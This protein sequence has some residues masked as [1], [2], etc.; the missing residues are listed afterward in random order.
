MRGREPSHAIV[1]CGIID[2][3]RRFDLR[4]SIGFFLLSCTEYGFSGKEETEPVLVRDTGEPGLVSLEVT[5]RA[6]DFGQVQIGEVVEEIVTVR[7]VGERAVRIDG[8]GLIDDTR[9]FTATWTGPEWLEPGEQHE[10]TV[11][12]LPLLSQ[13]YAATLYVESDDPVSGDDQV[14]L[15]GSTLLPNVHLSPTFYDFGE[16]YIDTHEEASF[17][18]SNLGLGNLMVTDLNWN[19]TSG[20]LSIFDDAGIGDGPL[21]IPGK[22]SVLLTVAYDPIDTAPDEATL[23]IY[24]EDPYEPEVYAQVGGTGCRDIIET[25]SWS[26]W[27]MHE[28]EGIQ[29]FAPPLP[30]IHGAIEE[31]DYSFVPPETDPGWTGAPD[32][33][34]IDY[35]LVPSSLCDVGAACLAAGEFTYFQTFVDLP[36]DLD[37][38]VFTVSFSGLDDGARVTIFNSASPS[39]IVVPGSYVYLGGSGTTNLAAYVV[40]GE[41]NRVVV[42]HVDDCCSGS[43]LESAILV[44]EG[45]ALQPCVP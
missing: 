26:P 38:D 36:S 32:P 34:Q 10:V 3:M 14:A 1:I 42:T 40:T 30:T 41:V 9:S 31:Y 39:G 8:L 6:I 15:S 35:S 4:L 12:F 29:Y 2:T 19:T 45:E 13:D 16:Q 17:T 20:E 44:I 7:S 43:Y 24:S 27:Q 21:T 5:P 37:L 33:Y 25:P 22:S 23:T 18:L 28:G 11:G